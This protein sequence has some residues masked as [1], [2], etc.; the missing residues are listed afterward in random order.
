MFYFDDSQH[1]RGD[2]VLGAFVIFEADPTPAISAAILEAGL[3]PGEDEYKSRHLHAADARWVQLRLSLFGIAREATVGVVVAP[4][5]DRG[6]FGLHGLMGLA[7]IMR[8]NDIARPASVFLDQ[9]LF[10][11]PHDFARACRTAGVPSDIRIES[12]CDSRVV[13]GIQVADLVAPAGASGLFGRARISDKTLRSD[14]EDE[15]QLSFEMWARLRYNFFRRRITDPALEAA[16]RSGLVDSSGGLYVA[17]G[18]PATIA[19]AAEGRFGKTWLGSI[20]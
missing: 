14:E 20:H 6:N 12:E 5:A 7:H 2:F 18:T 3:R 4:F 9:G 17:P 19:E 1:R 11:S 16:A 8:A 13:L 10:Q 15:Y